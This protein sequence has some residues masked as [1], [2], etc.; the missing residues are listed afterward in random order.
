M[1]DT[2]KPGEIVD[3]TALVG[4]FKNRAELQ[5]YAEVLFK[6]FKEAVQKL[7]ALEDENKHLKALLAASV[8]QLPTTKL[9]VPD[10]Q[11]IAEIQL[12][13]LKDTA[14]E[15]PLT[16]DETKRLDLLVKT[17]YLAKGKPPKT[18]SADPSKDVTEAELIQLVKND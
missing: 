3:V 8:P 11:V 4:K 6:S 10:E 16:L 7:Q 13:Q 2:N 12:R 17:L 1:D 15:R 14:M 5:K 18:I 9:V